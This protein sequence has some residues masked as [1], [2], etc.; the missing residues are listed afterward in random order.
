MKILVLTPMKLE[1]E[2]FNSSLEEVKKVKKLKNSYFTLLTG[3]GK[4]SVAA[5]TLLEIISRPYDMVAVVGYAAGTKS[6]EV[7]DFVCP[8]SAIQHDVKIS[9]EL[10]KNPPDLIKKYPLVGMDDYLLLTGDEFISGERSLELQQKY[11]K[12]VIYDMEGAAVAQVCY[13]LKVP[14]VVAKLISDVPEMGDC[15]KIFKDSIAKLDDF[16]PIVHFLES[17]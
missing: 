12:N 17:L 9:R 10:F 14:V 8:Q 3:I 16:K 7:G 15:E 6:M 11:G 4:V 13:D 2:Y 1:Y 5:E